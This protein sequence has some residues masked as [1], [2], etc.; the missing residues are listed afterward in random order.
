MSDLSHEARALIEAARPAERPP[1]EAKAKVHAAL[2]ARMASSPRS[3]RDGG[4]TASPTGIVA[5]SHAKLALVSTLAVVV[6]LGAIGAARY[7][8]SSSAKPTDPGRP[9]AL[10]VIS[11]ETASAQAQHLPQS[12][13]MAG[14]E[15]PPPPQPEIDR[16]HASGT[17]ASNKEP[18]LQPPSPARVIPLRDGRHTSRPESATSNAQLHGPQAMDND[19]DLPVARYSTDTLPTEPT[20]CSTREELRLLT[21][22]QTA[23]RD[24]HGREALALLDHHAVLCPR[25]QFSEEHSAAHILALCLVHRRDEA[26]RET[27]RLALDIPKSPQLAR[28]RSSCAAAAL[29]GS[30][31]DE[32][33]SER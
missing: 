11:P 30:M 22:A 4:T 24:R 15:F 31:P 17:R 1:G 9:P 19:T 8:G 7:W 33:P 27:A 28:L 21:D 16:Q 23:L 2:A 13:T 6:G 3:P 12:S 26:L 10:S 14:P 18:T 32:N 25:T 5:G 29:T 20:G